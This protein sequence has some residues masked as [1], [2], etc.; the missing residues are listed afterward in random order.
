MGV[1]IR[2]GTHILSPPS[3]LHHNDHKSG[4]LPCSQEA[5]EVRRT[6]ILQVGSFLWSSLQG[7]GWAGGSQRPGCPLR[8]CTQP[9]DESSP[10]LALLTACSGNPSLVLN[11]QVREPQ[12]RRERKRVTWF[13]KGE[14]GRCGFLGSLMLRTL[15]TFFLVHY[16][17]G[18]ESGSDKKYLTGDH[19]LGEKGLRPASLGRP[20]L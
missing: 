1:Q 7:P 20:A 15:H 6:V 14:T 8:S 3:P 2:K 16:F 10:I 17:S 11:A 9:G 13:P 4:T 19:S 5:L 18:E 12:G